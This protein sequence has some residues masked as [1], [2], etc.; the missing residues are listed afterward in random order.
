A[1]DRMDRSSASTVSLA[2]LSIGA[3][4]LAMPGGSW[5]VIELLGSLTAG[6][7]A[8]AASGALQAATVDGTPASNAGRVSGIASTG[9]YLGAA[10][11]STLASVGTGHAVLG[12]CAG[13]ASV[14][15]AAALAAGIT[16][17]AHGW[18][19]RRYPPVTTTVPAVP[20]L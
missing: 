13:L 9:R 7:G 6:I 4:P 1:S 19:T 11:G 14:P 3:V 12:V 16:R 17:S 20:A 8:G 15:L 5:F 10:I 2:A 18:R